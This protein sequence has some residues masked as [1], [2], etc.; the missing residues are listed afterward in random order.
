MTG[1]KKRILVVDDE[2]MITGILNTFLG[3]TGAYEVQVENHATKALQTARQ[4]KPDLILLDVHMPELEG[5]E[6]A[7][8]IR[9]DK[10]LKDTPIVFLTALIQRGE[11]RQSGGII[12][13]FPFIAKPLDP[14]MVDDTIREVLAA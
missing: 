2:L 10:A 4:F 8:L 9:E 13:G 5:G 14:K 3:G 12:G 1:T 6:V 7:A 11:V